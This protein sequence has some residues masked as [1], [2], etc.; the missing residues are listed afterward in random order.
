MRI[1]MMVLITLMQTA[2]AEQ[3]IFP[4][5][6]QKLAELYHEENYLRIFEKL[7]AISIPSCYF[8]LLGFY[9]FFHLGLNTCAEILKFGDRCFY[10]VRTQLSFYR[11]GGIARI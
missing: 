4:S 10:K 9:N 8:W 11:I 2:I 7:L 5:I 1:G 6:E 3:Y